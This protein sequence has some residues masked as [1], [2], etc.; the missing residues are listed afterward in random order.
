MATPVI[1]DFQ[2]YIQLDIHGITDTSS[3]TTI[4]RQTH[5]DVDQRRMSSRP[6]DRL[7]GSFYFWGDIFYTTK[8]AM[9]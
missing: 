7:G 5:F 4:Y 6:V 8:C 3:W 9:E 1:F 2:L